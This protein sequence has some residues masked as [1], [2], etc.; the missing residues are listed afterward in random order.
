MTEH[1]SQS[2]VRN[3]ELNT[4]HGCFRTQPGSYDFFMVLN[5]EVEVLE[6]GQR[7]YMYRE[8]LIL[9]GAGTDCGIL[10]HGNNL[11]LIVSLKESFFH[12][13]LSE[14]TGKFV[15]NS[16]TDKEKN[17]LILR[18]Y[19]SRMAMVYYGNSDIC[20]MNLNSLAYGLLYYLNAYHYYPA[21]FPGE[22]LSKKH[23]QRMLQIMDIVSHRFM[24]PLTLNELAGEMYLSVSYLSRFI[25]QC[26]G[27][28]FN[29][30]LLRVRME[31]AVAMLQ[32]SDESITR[33]AHNSGFSNMNT[34]NREFKAAYK[35]TPRE[36]R[37]LLEGKRKGMGIPE[38]KIIKHDYE[39]VREQLK[40]FADG[41][42]NI[43]GP[44][45]Y[46]GKYRYLVSCDKKGR[47]VEP[48]WKSLVN[49]G[50]ADTILNPEVQDQ[51]RRAQA[52]IGFKYGKIRCVLNDDTIAYIKETDSYNFV[53]FD[54]MISF[55]QSIHL[56]PVL[57]LNFKSAYMILEGTNTVFSGVHDDE[58]FSDENIYIRKIHELLNHSIYYF[59]LEYV[60]LWIF[61][62]G[63]YEEKSVL[64]ENAASF[65][66]RMKKA[67]NVIKAHAP[68]ALV[69]GLAHKVWAPFEHFSGIIEEMDRQGYAP[70]FISLSIIPYEP[71][72]EKADPMGNCFFSPDGS[73]ALTKVRKIRGYL[74]KYPSIPNRIF[75]TTLCVDMIPRNVLNDSCFLSAFLARTLLLLAG[76]VEMLGYWQFSDIAT[77][78]VDTSNLLHGGNGLVSKYGIPKPGYFVL[79]QMSGIG[80]T[81]LYKEDGCMVT[82]GQ[83]GSYFAV[84]ENFVRLN[85]LYCMQ[86]PRDIP[87]E[88][89]YSVFERPSVKDITLELNGLHPGKYKV[90]IATLNRKS[91]SLL[92]SWLESGLENPMRK[93]EIEYLR[94]DVH[95][96]CQFNILECEDKAL[97]LRMQMLPHEV[98]FVTIREVSH[99]HC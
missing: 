37:R 54:R 18:R 34:F 35:C 4:I 41:E 96:K 88:D 42:V 68:R 95:V 43:D 50:F 52:D 61:E 55:L 8:D 77:E 39:T 28:N 48:L 30:Y 20:S 25:K 66:R 31:N 76:E 78:Y 1:N 15:C 47:T 91:G 16:V 64:S 10:A 93:S 27:E 74:E 73:Y 22:T 72:Y 80:K 17:Y 85:D 60:D 83:G 21:K 62:I 29:A 14:L 89:I 6:N 23:E 32:S 44:V 53:K 97:E 26:F 63:Y 56:I 87:A 49:L 82:S 59:G 90:T 51:L 45:N 46:P 70:D 94:N 19:L 2:P 81:L 58:N 67:A 86:A 92:D 38:G 40:E 98:K 84:L 5:G 75:V 3:I 71:N 33:I 7:Y 69:G 13:G 65:V 57:D 79:S 11:I 36:Y 99:L 9:I 12:Q 24:Q